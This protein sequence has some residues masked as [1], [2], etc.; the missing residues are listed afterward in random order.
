[1]PIRFRRTVKVLPGVKLNMSKGGVSVTV[2]TKGFHLNFGKR[3][4]RQTIGLP[5]SGIS[6]TSYLIK[7]KPESEHEKE[8]ESGEETHSEKRDSE[9]DNQY[10]EYSLG[11]CFLYLLVLTVVVYLV[12]N[13]FGWIPPSYLSQILEQVTQRIQQAGL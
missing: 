4:V 5:G 2:G 10:V 6:E 7:N 11:S 9:N 12:A 3:G 1:M 8:K 13:T